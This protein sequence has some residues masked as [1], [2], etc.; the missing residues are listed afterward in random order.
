MP[1]IATGL[2]LLSL[3]A[4]LLLSARIEQ[5]ELSIREQILRLECHMAG[6]AEAVG[7]I[8]RKHAE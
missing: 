4:V 7:H 1:L 5:A 3:G 6:F 2:A 8:R